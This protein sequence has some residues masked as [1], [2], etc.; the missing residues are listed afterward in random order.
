MK[1]NKKN[2]LENYIIACTNFYGIIREDQLKKIYFKHHNEPIDL[3]NINHEY[4]NHFF[5]YYKFQFFMIEVFLE[6]DMISQYIGKMNHKPI[7]YPTKKELMKYLDDSYIEMNDAITTFVQ[8]INEHTPKSKEVQY[9]NFIDEVL[10]SQNIGFDLDR[11]DT[12]MTRN[13]VYTLKIQD[14]LPLVSDVCEHYRLWV[15]NG[16][17]NS[18]LMELDRNDSNIDIL[19]YGDIDEYIKKALEKYHNEIQTL[20]VKV[21]IDIYAFTNPSLND[22]IKFAEND[23]SDLFFNV[24]PVHIL[25]ALVR[26]TYEK[27]EHK[28]TEK[29]KE[30]YFRAL[31]IWTQKEEADIIYD[32]LTSAYEIFDIENYTIYL[33]KFYETMNYKPIKNVTKEDIRRLFYTQKSTA[34][35]SK[36]K[37]KVEKLCQ[38]ITKGSEDSFEPLF[39]LCNIYPLSTYV[40]YEFTVYSDSKYDEILLKAI[41]Q[42]FELSYPDLLKNAL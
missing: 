32:N 39:N 26:M 7:Y 23:L 14:V 12:V 36:I 11:L 41:V 31:G 4:L 1:P 29:R 9:Q 24:K 20:L 3:S 38:L 17:T 18:E 30:Y 42:S 27:N 13:G 35:N 22:L 37:S 15:N 21:P 25:S 28:F 10:F 16:Y 33:Q 40:L 8:Y 5:I 19:D 34:I 6:E 2:Q